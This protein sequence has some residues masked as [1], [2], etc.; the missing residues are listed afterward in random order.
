MDLTPCEKDKLL[1]FT[2]ALLATALPRA[3]CG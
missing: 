3:A 1:N 2:A